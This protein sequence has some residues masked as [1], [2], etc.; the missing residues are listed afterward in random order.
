MLVRTGEPPRLTRS[1]FAA[2]DA[3]QRMNVHASSTREAAA[4]IAQYQTPRIPAP[5]GTGASPNFPASSPAGPLGSFSTGTHQ[6]QLIIWAARPSASAAIESSK[7]Q[8]WVP[9]GADDRYT[10]AYASRAVRASGESRT[11]RSAPSWT[12]P[13]AANR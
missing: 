10:S 9:G 2:F 5:P 4:G 13:P 8:L 12:A 7:V 3:I 11:T 1:A 6:W